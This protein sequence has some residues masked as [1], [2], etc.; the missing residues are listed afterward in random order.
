VE[1]LVEN[2]MALE[3]NALRNIVLERVVAEQ[4]RRRL[5]QE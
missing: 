4:A 5:G 1:L 2:L 3:R